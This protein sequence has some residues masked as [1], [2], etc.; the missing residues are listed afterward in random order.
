MTEIAPEDP[1]A[2]EVVT[3][4]QQGDVARLER[5]LAAD[6]ALATARIRGRTLLHIL[7]D[8]PGHRPESART[9]KLLAQHGADVNAR[10]QHPQQKESAETPLHWAA[11]SDD[12]AL[13]DALLDAGADIE[14]DGAIFTGGA[15]MSDAVVF[16]QWNAARQLLARG[17]KTTFWQASA[18]GLSDQVEGAFRSGASPSKDEITNAFWNACRGGHRPVAEYL[19]KQGADRNW[20]GHDN[21]TPLDVAL[22]SGNADFIAWLR[23]T[24]A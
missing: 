22:E 15:P 18:L 8:W 16:A 10:F 23:A 7:A 3:A 21:K 12:V 1:R 2:A 11:S 14:V 13:I 17:A 4:I 20:V 5:M 19:L 9:A 6:A 24:S